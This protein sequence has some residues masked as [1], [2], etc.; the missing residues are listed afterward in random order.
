VG[1]LLHLLCL[2]RALVRC[3]CLLGRR[4]LHVIILCVAACQLLLHLGLSSSRLCSLMR[5][6]CRLNS[7]AA[8]I[9]A[10]RRLTS[11]GRLHV[12]RIVQAAHVLLL[13]LCMLLLRF[14]GCVLCTARVLLVE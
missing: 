11:R 4:L 3:F 2:A 8:L 13:V 5:V 9:S 10:L 6:L 7:A 1:F 12:L 14:L